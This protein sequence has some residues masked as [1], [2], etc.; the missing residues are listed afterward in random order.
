M[1]VSK[2]IRTAPIPPTIQYSNLLIRSNYTGKV[3]KVSDVAKVYETFEEENIIQKTDAK[4]SINLVVFKRKNGD[5]LDI[6]KKLR[7]IVN[8]YKKIIP[9]DI[10]ITYLNDTSFYIKR[11]LTTLIDNSIYGIIFVITSLLLFISPPIAISLWVDLSVIL[12]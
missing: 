12:S 5:A 11:R 4:K 1:S 10:K 9:N 8:D 6:V 3:T 7:Q 2:V